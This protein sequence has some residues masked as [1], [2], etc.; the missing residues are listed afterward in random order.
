MS[1]INLNLRSKVLE[2]LTLELANLA[3]ALQL[4]SVRICLWK[5]REGEDGGGRA[6]QG[7]GGGG[8][9]V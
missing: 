8:G 4:C 9:G 3:D 5:R 2:P 1:G 7:E 6:V